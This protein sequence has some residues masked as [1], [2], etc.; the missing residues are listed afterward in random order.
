[1]FKINYNF[2]RFLPFI[3][4]IHIIILSLIFLGCILQG[5]KSLSYPITRMQLGIMVIILWIFII[6]DINYESEESS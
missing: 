2:E 6:Y 4:Y 1:M 5:K 3:F